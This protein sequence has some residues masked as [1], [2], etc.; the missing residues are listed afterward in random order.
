[1]TAPA[2]SEQKTVVFGLDGATLDCIRP[3][4]A[5]GLLPNMARLMD[6]GCWGPL[7][8]T[9]HPITPQAWSSF[10]TGMN[11]G[12]HGVYDFT[13]RR[14]GTYEL[15]FIN[16][17]KRQSESI[18]SIM[19]RHG[20]TAGAIAVPFTFPP[21]RLERGFMLSGLDSPGEDGRSVSPPEIYDEIKSQFGAYYI[22]LGS[23]VGRKNDPEALWR[24]MQ[25]EDR[26]RTDVSLHLMRTRPCDLFI[27][28]YNNVDRIQHND[29]DLDAEAALQSGR[30]PKNGHLVKAYQNADV[31]LGK[32]LDEL[33]GDTTV[34][35]ISDHGAGP[36]R[37]VFHLN[38]WLELEGMLSMRSEGRMV[39]AV[40]G[41]RELSK[42][43][44]PRWMKNFVK[45]RLGRMQEKIESFV[46]LSRIDWRST[47]AYGLGMYGNIHINLKG[48]EPEGV[49]EPGAEY[50]ALREEIVSKL[51]A[52]TDPDTGERVIERVWRREEIYDGPLTE[53]APDLLIGWKDY[54]YYTSVSSD[55]A[56][57]S[58][59]TGCG[60]IDAS[61]FVHN[62]THRLAGTLIAR[63]PHIRK[64][65]IEGARLLDSA[66][67][68]LYLVGL[69]I[70]EDMDGR[71]LEEL[72]DPDFIVRNPPRFEGVTHDV[73]EHDFSYSEEEA[74]DV[75]ERLK[76]LGYL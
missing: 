21:E 12:R 66:P 3:M 58:I 10:L 5:A 30:M 39:S 59:F 46:F 69:P 72:F 47:K 45:S 15:E 70:P 29:Y 40:R 37:K 76:G 1:M 9:I 33:D 25:Q 8:S 27:T 67:T 2:R 50:D 14:V 6:E 17:S 36:I 62:G 63:G 20:K 13:R 52:L 51:M 31:Q 44:M 53:V 75:E 24:D 38:N 60:N 56:R 23:P 4:A 19:A 22:H 34:L 61:D 32:I 71:V 28:V 42:R 48:R 18:L 43:L 68:M 54:A 73:D 7:T 16:A 65:R 49:V 11:A 26:N 41:S 57:G 35:I 74:K 64:G 55:A